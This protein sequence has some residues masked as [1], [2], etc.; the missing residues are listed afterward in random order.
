V[1]M[2]RLRH[3]W[4]VKKPRQGGRDMLEK[5]R[6]E[7]IKAGVDLLALVKSRGIDLKKNGKGYFGLCPFHDDTNPSLSVNPSTNL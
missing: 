1:K 5:E 2:V 6:I 3:A 4:G 7:A